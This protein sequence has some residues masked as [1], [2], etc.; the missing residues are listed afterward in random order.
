MRT[1][2]RILLAS[3]GAALTGLVASPA[4]AQKDIS[5]QL[6]NV[7]LLVDTSGSMEYLIPTDPTDPTGTKLMLPGNV[8]APNSACNINASTITSAP[9]VKNRWSTLLEVMTGTFTSYGCE[10]LDRTFGAAGGFVNEYK[11]FGSQPYDTNYY[12]PFHRPYSNNCTQGPGN[13]GTSWNPLL[14]PTSPDS[15]F[16]VHSPPPTSL[17]CG[18]PSL[19]SYQLSDG[20]LDVF[21]D[22]VRF[23]L[24]TFDSSTDPGTGVNGS[25]VVSGANNSVGLWSYYAGWRTN[26]NTYAK[27]F[28]VGCATPSPIEVGA[29]NEGA[30]PW[31]GR[32]IPLDPQDATLATSQ[33]TNARIQDELLAMRPYGATP[34]A[35]MMADAKLN[36]FSDT[37]V[38]P[39]ATSD[40]ISPK[41]DAYWKDG[42]RKQFIIVLSDGAPNLDLFGQCD[43]AQSQANG[44]GA[45]S[46]CPYPPAEQTAKDLRVSPPTPNQSVQTFVIGFGV[47]APAA[48]KTF[49]PAYTSCS[50]LTLSDCA[51]SSLPA[52]LAPCCALQKIALNGSDPTAPQPALFADDPLSLKQQLSKVLSAIASGSTARTFPV[53]S[54]TSSSA[55][56][57]GSNL[58]TPAASYQFAASFQVPT[59]GELWYGNLVRERSACV[60]GAPVQQPVSQTLGDD[61]A[62]NVNLN[63]TK[64]PRQFFTAVP[65][66]QLQSLLP[67]VLGRYSDRSLRANIALPDDGLG[68]DKPDTGQTVLQ[69]LSNAS[70]FSAA[71]GSASS[72][73]GILSG[74]APQ[75]LSAF[76][77]PASLDPTLCAKYTMQWEVGLDNSLPSDKTFRTRNPVTCPI[78]DTCNKLGAIY[79]STPAVIGPPGDLISDDT[80]TKYGYDQA[81]SAAGAVPIMLY[82][83]TTDGQLHAFKV[84]SSDGTKD[85]FTID[86]AVQNELWSFFPPHVLQHLLGSYNQQ[87]VLLDGSPVVQDVVLDRDAATATATWNRVLVAGSGKSGFGGFYYAL[88]VTNPTA[89]KFLWQLSQDN[90][91]NPLFGSNTSTPAITTVSIIG[92]TGTRR[93]VAVAIL[94]GGSGAFASSCTTP[95]ASLVTSTSSIMSVNESTNFNNPGVAK[96]NI[97]ATP[98]NCWDYSSNTQRSSGNAL[99]IVRLDTGEVLAHFRGPNYRGALDKTIISASTK[100]NAKLIDAPFIAPVTGIPVAFPGDVGQVADRVFVGD[101]DGVLWRI[102]VSD[103]N[104]ANWKALMAW[105]TYAIQGDTRQDREAIQLSPILSRDPLGNPVVIIATGDQD[106][107]TDVTTS[108]RVVSLTEVAGPAPNFHKVGQNW[109]IPFGKTQTYSNRRVTG[110]MALFNSVLYFATFK[111]DSTHACADGAASVWAVDYRRPDPAK[112]GYP[113]P[114][115]PT[116]PLSLFQ[117]ADTGSVIFGVGVSASASCSDAASGSDGYF[118]GHNYVSNVSSPTYSVSWQTGAGKGLST[119]GGSPVSNDPTVAGLQKMKIPSPGQATKIDSWGSLVE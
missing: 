71:V 4:L 76:G 48:L 2:T 101:S 44:F 100:G 45:G 66:E 26:T 118:G 6:P 33:A 49:N 40:P 103:P 47:S 107:F 91:G 23:G 110:P 85:K 18:T 51:S 53:F 75:C 115:F 67:P 50:N 77:L 1:L 94:P 79:H 36:L 119:T 42:C 13:I 106:T 59:G 105:D 102:D 95:P 54:T 43:L 52:A 29:R 5:P 9:T 21:R 58:T 34:L 114:E 32:L 117:D 112:A 39:N 98:F 84:S 20:L 19:S 46:S 41:N 111:P 17:N 14:W 10:R 65:T 35:G 7:L 28:P 15:P 73:L 38:V 87:A 25:A 63:D 27:G 56:A 93:E 80:Y 89:P 99:T 69:S 30:P 97:Q 86:S 83:A 72:L 37:N 70:D 61:F 62:Y 116:S 68:L 3:G 109:W 12:L 55:T 81:N 90:N 57:Q 11:G 22:R 82:T 88:D 64:P 96:F 60:S 16:T 92:P 74:S 78:G 31:E 108:A 8:N 104:V 24:M 113:L